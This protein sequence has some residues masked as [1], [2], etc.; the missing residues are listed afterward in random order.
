[1][2]NI[3]AM[4]STNHLVQA[5]IIGAVL[6]YLTA[7]LIINAKIN[8]IKTT[9]N[10]WS[11]TLQ[12]GR[13]G[14]GVLLRAASAK[15]LPAVNIAEEA[16]YYTTTV[17]SEKKTLNGRHNY[18]LHFP[19]GELPPNDAFWSL[20]MT[21]VVGYMVNN[22]IDRYA[23]GDRSGLVQNSDGSTDIYIQGAAPAGHEANWLPSPAGKFKLWLRVYL[24]GQA[25]LDGKYQVPPVRKVG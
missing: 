17:D 6:A 19:A 14:S 3:S 20:T 13:P 22:P 8:A 1:M 24:P 2:I 15:F 9:V 4:I 18:L 12:C 11:T 10:G 7:T 21:D 25:V 23:L 5:V 16:V